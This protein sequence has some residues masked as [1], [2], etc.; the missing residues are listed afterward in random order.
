MAFDSLLD[1]TCDIY[2]MRKTDKSPGYGLPS[3][4]S[5]SYETVPDRTAIPCHFSTKA[6]TGGGI[7]IIQGDPQAR[8]EAKIKLVLPLGTDV[9]LNDKI[10]DCDMGYAY[11]AEVPRKIRD[12][13][14]TVMLHRTSAQEAL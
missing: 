5:F 6:G 3:S 14:L 1:H 2:H 4:P 10:V 11:T 12:H 8:L 7:T 9:Q 13:H